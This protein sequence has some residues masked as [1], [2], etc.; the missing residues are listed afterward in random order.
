VRIRTKARIIAMLACTA[1]GLLRTPDRA[2]APSWV[3]TNGKE[4]PKLR[5]EGI[6]DCDTNDSA[7]SRVSWNMKSEGNRSWFRLTCCLKAIGLTPYNSAS[8]RSSITLW[9]RRKRILSSPTAISGICDFLAMVRRLSA[10]HPAAQLWKEVMGGEVITPPEGAEAGCT[11]VRRSVGVS[12]RKAVRYDRSQ[13]SEEGP[14]SIAVSGPV[15]RAP[16]R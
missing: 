16:H 8:S 5:S 10:Q 9:P 1:F 4:P 15:G 12:F 3:K 6:T 13:E 11:G 14:S 2:A 7:S